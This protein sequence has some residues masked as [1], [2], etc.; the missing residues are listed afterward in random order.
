[1]V[2]VNERK[3]GTMKTKIRNIETK[4]NRY[5]D[6]YDSDDILVTDAGRYGKMVSIGV[7]RE[8]V[9]RV[10]DTPGVTV[11]G[12]W[13]FSFGQAVIV[14]NFGTGASARER[15][16]KLTLGEEFTIDHVPGVYR[17]RAPQ[18]GEGESPLLERIDEQD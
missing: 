8:G 6:E 4:L 3:V 7:V 9:E 18:P 5:E 16:I 17:F 2:K 11:P 14:D 10:K 12:P 13:A 1:M 15:A